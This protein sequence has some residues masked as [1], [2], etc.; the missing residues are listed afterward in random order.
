[1]NLFA[2]GEETPH[3][4]GRRVLEVVQA[5]IECELMSKPVCQDTFD[6]AVRLGSILEQGKELLEATDGMSPKEAND[7]IIEREEFKRSFYG[8]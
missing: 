4:Y 2:G 1:M 3:Q 6:F 7:Y 8:S 5:I